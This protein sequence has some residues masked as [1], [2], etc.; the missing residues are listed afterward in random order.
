MTIVTSCTISTISIKGYE[1]TLVSQGAM[2]V[3][4]SIS[5]MVTLIN[6]ACCRQIIFTAMDL[7]VQGWKFKIPRIQEFLKVYLQPFPPLFKFSLQVPTYSIQINTNEALFFKFS[8]NSK[9]NLFQDTEIMWTTLYV[10]CRTIYSIANISITNNN[11][12][13][14][15]RP[16]WMA[17]KNVDLAKLYYMPV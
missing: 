10:I 11:M 12:H 4:S 2:K 13:V 8:A 9:K 14:R 17:K 16:C 5:F 15:S 7:Y 6:L 1:I 3:Q